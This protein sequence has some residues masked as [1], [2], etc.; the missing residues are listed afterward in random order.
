MRSNESPHVKISTPE[1]LQHIRKVIAETS[2][3]SWI[4]SVPR[5]YGEARAGVLKA[6]EW[7][8]LSTIYLPIALISIWGVGSYH[9]S[10]NET[11]RFS[12]VL[13]HTML[14]VSA[15]MIGCKR[16]MS[17]SRR[18]AYLKY[19]TQYI[20]NLLIIHPDASVRPYAHLSLH[21]PYFF[22]LFG[23]ARCF[24]T[25]PFERLIGQIQRLMTNHKI[26]D[27]NSL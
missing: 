14:L 18:D 2:T 23:P 3:P 21:L 11:S 8:T 16:T 6:D 1:T 9:P 5:N 12:E 25:Y 4:E 7:R 26:G 24:W 22:D 17:H 27:S 15:V 10:P 19:M 20:S 13:D